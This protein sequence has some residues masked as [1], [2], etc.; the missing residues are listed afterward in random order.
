MGV[1]LFVQAWPV[2]ALQVEIEDPHQLVGRRQRH[3]LPTILQS[4]ALND[5]VKHLGLKSRDDM[6]EVRRVQN[7]I[8]SCGT[9]LSHGDGHDEPIRAWAAMIPVPTRNKQS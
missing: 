4:T 6:R 1:Q 8:E 2:T 7:A 3:E 5:P 9:K